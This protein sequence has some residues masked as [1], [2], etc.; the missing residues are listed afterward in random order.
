MMRARSTSSL[1]L[2]LGI[3][4]TAGCCSDSALEGPARYSLLRATSEEWPDEVE[5]AVR[6]SEWRFLPSLRSA[7][8]DSGAGGRWALAAD[9]ITRIDPQRSVA[10][11]LASRTDGNAAVVDRAIEEAGRPEVA[12]AVLGVLE[13]P[14]FL[15][16]SLRDDATVGAASWCDAHRALLDDGALKDRLVPVFSRGIRR[17]WPDATRKVLLEFAEEAGVLVPI[18][19]TMIPSALGSKRL[20]EEVVTAGCR[21]DR[22]VCLTL[23]QH[24]DVEVRA[25]AVRVA[26]ASD[27][28]DALLV[29]FGDPDAQVSVRAGERLVM[30]GLGGIDVMSAVLQTSEMDSVR[31]KAVDNLSNMGPEAAPALGACMRQQKS[32]ELRKACFAV[33]VEQAGASGGD[34]E[35]PA[36]DE[37]VTKPPTSPEDCADWLDALT[38]LAAKHGRS[39]IIHRG[40]ASYLDAEG[41]SRF[42]A[43]A[44]ER[45]DPEWYRSELVPRDFRRAVSCAVKKEKALTRAKAAVERARKNRALGEALILV[46]D[47]TETAKAAVGT[48]HAVSAGANVGLDGLHRVLVDAPNKIEAAEAHPQYKRAVA[49]IRAVNLASERRQA[50]L[51]DYTGPLSSLLMRWY[52]STP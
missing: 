3:L 27:D 10:N 13:A 43:D 36:L 29:G 2:L 33:L 34:L 4:G 1:L 9:A 24:E 44:L 41:D 49:L 11:L 32:Q 22:S 15:E 23:I 51:S 45:R 14:P 7:L 38:E 6:D 17:D 19:L 20:F 5:K 21:K 37:L 12:A 40:M 47:A 26:D 18:A 28:V 25:L 16:E 30:R 46:S 35:T 39:E 42:L 48:I 50:C 8:R 52:Y 31:R